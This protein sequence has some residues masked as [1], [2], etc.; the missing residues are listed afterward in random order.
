MQITF[1]FH[2][3]ST[4]ATTPSFNM[5]D[6]PAEAHFSPD[7]NINS[8]FPLPTEG[9][10]KDEAADTC[11]K[12]GDCHILVYDNAKNAL[13]ESYRSNLV[14]NNLHSTCAIKWDLTKTY[15]PTLRGDQCTRTEAAGLPV[16]PLVFTADK[17][18]SGS[19]IHAIRFVLPNASVSSSFVRPATHCHSRQFHC[20]KME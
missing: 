9:A 8:P 19:I 17:I 16:T 7:C 20:K 3:L 12:D 6:L 14:G 5:V 2:I 4:F 15:I 1:S 13:Y 11:T 10:I 18:A